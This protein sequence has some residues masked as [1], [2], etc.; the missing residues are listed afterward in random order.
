[1]FAVKSTSTTSL[2]R[3]TIRPLTISPRGVGISRLSCL[4]TYSRSWIVET[5]VA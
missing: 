4:T 2:K 3:S 5:M 1:M